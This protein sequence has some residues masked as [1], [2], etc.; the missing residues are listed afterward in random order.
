MSYNGMES[1]VRQRLREKK[2]QVY[3]AGCLAIDLQQD[4]ADIRATMDELARGQNFVAGACP[5]G[6]TGLGYR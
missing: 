1:I 6:G 5:C 2:G 4:P 3:C